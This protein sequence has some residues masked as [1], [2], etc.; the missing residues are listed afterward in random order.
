MNQR[1]NQIPSRQNCCE[2]AFPLGVAIQPGVRNQAHFHHNSKS[3]KANYFPA[4]M[5]KITNSSSRLSP[6]NVEGKKQ[7]PGWMEGTPALVPAPSPNSTPV[8]SAAANHQGE[9]T[10]PAERW[11][12]RGCEQ[13]VTAAKDFGAGEGGQQRQ[14]RARGRELSALFCGRLWPPRLATWQTL[15]KCPS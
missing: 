13:H 3:M 11:C 2:T 12:L 1:N 7:R 6:Y 4:K 15:R 10:S 8:P 14:E 5:S 9:A